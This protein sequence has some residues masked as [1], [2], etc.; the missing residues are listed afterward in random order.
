MKTKI[1]TT[2]K[3]EVGI[4][5]PYYTKSYSH[6]FKFINERTIIVIHSGFQYKTFSI[7]KLDMSI[8]KTWLDSEKA[9]KEEFEAEYNKVLKLMKKELRAKKNS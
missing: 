1:K 8:P 4:E 7:E 9:T 6:M 5:F 2:T 3:E